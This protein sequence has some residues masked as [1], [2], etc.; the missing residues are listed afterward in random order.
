[1]MIGVDADETWRRSKACIVGWL[2]SSK[3]RGE[4]V[5]AAVTC[6]LKK[7]LWTR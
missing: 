7:C 6:M 5:I 1:L 3:C 2:M 4:K